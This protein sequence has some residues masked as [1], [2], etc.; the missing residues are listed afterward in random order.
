MGKT[1]FTIK[2][3]ESIIGMF[4]AAEELSNQFT[5]KMKQ[6]PTGRDFGKYQS[7]IILQSLSLEL[8]LKYLLDNANQTYPRTHSI[9]KLFEKL[10]GTLQNSIKNKYN[11]KQKENSN[12]SSFDDMLNE[13]DQLFVEWRYATFDGSHL[14]IQIDAWKYFGEI[15]KN[16]IA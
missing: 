2:R 9:K 7:S 1:R 8:S 14:N 13:I 11:E 4:D 3:N 16:K 5:Q 6:D 10:D 15:L 12:W